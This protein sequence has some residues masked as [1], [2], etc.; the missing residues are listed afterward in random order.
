[1]DA[2]QAGINVSDVADST[3]EFCHVSGSGGAGLALGVGDPVSSCTVRKN[4]VLGGS[5]QGLRCRGPDNVLID[6]RVQDAASWASTCSTP[7]R[8]P[9]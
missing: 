5:A 6:N 3:V 1:M 4:V 2:A 7:P 9:W 8:A